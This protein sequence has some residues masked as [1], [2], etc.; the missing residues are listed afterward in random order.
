[1]GADLNTQIEEAI[2]GLP[3]YNYLLGRGLAQPFNAANSGSRKLM[4]AIHRDHFLVPEHGEMP[5]I[6]T[7]FENEFGRA[8]SSF[9][10]ADYNYRVL[11]KIPKFNFR[12]EIHYYLVVQNLDTGEYDLIERNFLKHNTES[13][14]YL[15]NNSYLDKLNIGDTINKGDVI[16]KS[17]GFDESNNRL[18]GVNLTTL[19]MSSD[20]NMEDSIIISESAAAKMGTILVKY[21]V[22]TINDNDILL[23]LYGNENGLYKTFPDIGEDIRDN[24]FC[25]VRR[26]ENSSMLYTLSQSNLRQ[27]MMSDKNIILEGTVVDIDVYCNNP[28]TL[29]ESSY[30][31]QLYFYYN[32][33]LEFARAFYDAVSP[34]SMQGKLSY[35]LHALYSTCRDMIE[36]KLFFNDKPFNNVIMKVK[37]AQ[38][39]LASKGDKMS[40]RYGGKGV[41]SEIRPDSM[42]P[43]LD[44]GKIVEVIKNQSTCINRENLG[45]IHEQSLTFMASR[46]LDYC[47]MG[48]LSYPEQAHLIYDYIYEVEPALA[49][50]MV[51]T[52]NID[53]DYE[54]RIWVEQYLEDDCIVLSIPPFTTNIDIDKLTKMYDK[55]SWITPYKVTIPVKDSNGNIRYIPT[56]RPLIVGKI[57]NYRLKQYAKEK[58]SVTSLAATNIKNLN[59]KSKSNKVYESKFSRTP[60]MFGA[61]ESGNMAHLGMQYV[62]M[63]L[64]LY[65]SS[66]QGRRLFEKLLT[67]DP[68]E[69]DIK[70]DKD[71][72][73]RN[74]EI[75]NTI[76]KTMGLK[77]NFKK[78]AKKT[79]FLCKNIMFK[80]VRNKDFTGYKTNV[81]DIIGHDDELQ[82]RYKAAMSEPNDHPM[83]KNVMCKIVDKEKEDKK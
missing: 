63:N 67:G 66:P 43:R 68:Y 23:N 80:N 33:S 64:M 18:D 58:F 61:M 14:G 40:D 55:F 56:R 78:V 30:N 79:K 83:V 31:Q 52:C 10:E 24:I 59:T 76:F 11:Y 81:R 19:Y 27:P 69:I 12:P 62:V 21:P 5:I 26:L 9:V 35:S 71:S 45:Q 34:L 53:D 47:R 28:T 22:I 60:I 32:Q 1:M 57:Y 29:S 38:R 37:I 73:N 48:V 8:S 39:L 50:F 41:I 17:N 16:R 54:A 51:G 4:Y 46:I 77:L 3:D 72:K 42:M 49:D 82:L 70:L 25:S 13:Y 20:Q 75:I 7:G 65:S 15:Y 36:G 6:Q 2:Q 74:A 44:N